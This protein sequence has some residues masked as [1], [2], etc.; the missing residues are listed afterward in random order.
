MIGAAGLEKIENLP[1]NDKEIFEKIKKEPFHLLILQNQNFEKNNFD[2][3]ILKLDKVG[4]YQY[5]VYESHNHK[6]SKGQINGKVN[7]YF[8]NFFKITC[9]MKHSKIEFD[10]K[11]VFEN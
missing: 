6:N 7:I 2:N 3:D 11:C 8:I 1:K 10:K 4:D 9:E 5:L